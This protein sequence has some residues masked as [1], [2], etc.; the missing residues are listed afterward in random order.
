MLDPKLWFQLMCIV[1]RIFSNC[2]FNATPRKALTF[3]EI[4]VQW[5]LWREKQEKKVF[6]AYVGQIGEE[7]YEMLEEFYEYDLDMLEF[8][9]GD[10]Q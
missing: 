6:N 8:L 3:L 4:S 9:L 5:I 2:C 1:N 7:F 10:G